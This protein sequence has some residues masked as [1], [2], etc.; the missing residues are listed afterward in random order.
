MTTLF[1]ETAFENVVCKMAT[2]LFKPQYVQLY[3]GHMRTNIITQDTLHSVYGLSQ[4]ETTLHC[5]VVFHWLSPYPVS[6]NIITATYHGTYIHM[7]VYITRDIVSTQVVNK[8]LL[9]QV[10]PSI[11]IHHL[12]MQVYSRQ[13]SLIPCQVIRSHNIDYMIL[14]L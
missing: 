8:C 7:T 1:Q 14:N 3:M 2:T 12:F 9:L 11:T 6:S 4:W 5:N 13:I 10:M